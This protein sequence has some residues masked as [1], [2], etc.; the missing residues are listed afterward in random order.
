[1]TDTSTQLTKKDRISGK[2]VKTTLAGAVVD[3]GSGKLGVVP[4]SQLR[5]EPVRKV[6]EVLK[7]GDQVEVWVRRINADNGHIELTMIEPLAME[8]RE[9]KK[10]MILTGKVSKM[11]KFGAFVDLGAER[12]GLLHVSEMSHDYVRRPEDVV[13][14][15]DEIEVKVLGVDRR[16]KQIKLSIKALNPEPVIEEEPEQEPQKPAPTAMEVALRKA[17]AL[18]EERSDAPQSVATKKSPSPVMDDIL[19]RT[20]ENRRQ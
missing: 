16:K 3:I 8:W 18:S 7:E 19:S 13:K 2:V 14:V 4:I 9:L 5:K 12:P 17:M 1:M 15:G 20:L 11:E 10:D 6:E